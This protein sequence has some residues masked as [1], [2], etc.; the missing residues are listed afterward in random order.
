LDNWTART[1][2]EQFNKHFNRM[3]I[4]N[5]LCG[6]YDEADFVGVSKSVRRSLFLLRSGAPMPLL[7]TRRTISNYVAQIRQYGLDARVPYSDQQVIQLGDFF[8]E[9]GRIQKAPEWLIDAGRAPRPKRR[10]LF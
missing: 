10:K 8:S 6:T 5:A 4:L 1:A 9:P 3:P 7:F 2:K